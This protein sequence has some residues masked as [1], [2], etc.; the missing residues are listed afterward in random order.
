MTPEQETLLI[1]KGAIA[2]LTEAERRRVEV[3]EQHI[4]ALIQQ[5]K[6]AAVMAI[7]LVGAEL[8]AGS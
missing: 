2:E 8:Q 3:A 6:D 5:D 4:R 7:A 1:I